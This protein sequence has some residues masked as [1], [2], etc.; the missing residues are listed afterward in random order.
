MLRAKNGYQMQCYAMA[1][2]W[3]CAL[4]HDADADAGAG[5]YIILLVVFVSS[6]RMSSVVYLMYVAS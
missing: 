1:T 4:N 6:G 2:Q 5:R 3:E